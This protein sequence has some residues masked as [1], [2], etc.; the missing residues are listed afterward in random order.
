[1][2]VPSK[3]IVVLVV[4]S[5]VVSEPDGSVLVTG[6][7]TAAV[8]E[9]GKVVLLTEVLE[10][11]VDEPEVVSPLTIEELAAAPLLDGNVMELLVGKTAV[12]AS[13]LNAY[14]VLIEVTFG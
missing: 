8:I 2:P 5:M 6:M 11:E 10:V 1:V 3:P 13:L 12:S 7:M 14:V 9:V 4:S